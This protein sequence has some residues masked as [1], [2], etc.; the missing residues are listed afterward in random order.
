MTRL[1][2]LLAL[3]LNACAAGQSFADSMQEYSA[4]ANSPAAHRPSKG[5]A[6]SSNDGCP[7]GQVCAIDDDRNLTAGHCVAGAP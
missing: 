5:P 2:I 1:P 3:S 6:C 7:V 4:Q